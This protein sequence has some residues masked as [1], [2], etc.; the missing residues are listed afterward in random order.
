[1]STTHNSFPIPRELREELNLVH[2]IPNSP[3][4]KRS[5]VLRTYAKGLQK[6]RVP[7]QLSVAEAAGMFEV[8]MKDRA[9]HSGQ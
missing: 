5:E 8:W 3:Y 2:P 4:F 9:L 1:M 6:L 7:P